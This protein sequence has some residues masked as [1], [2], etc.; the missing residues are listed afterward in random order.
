MFAHR[1]VRGIMVRARLRGAR[2]NH[3]RC[4][5]RFR[6]GDNRLELRRRTDRFRRQ[7]CVR[8]IEVEKLTSPITVRT[9][10]RHSSAAP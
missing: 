9:I 8:Q 10:K 4:V 6:T 2:L 1:Y 5:I 7:H 3:G